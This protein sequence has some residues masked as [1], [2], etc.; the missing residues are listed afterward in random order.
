MVENVIIYKQG[1]LINM[2]RSP[3]CS[4]ITDEKKNESKVFLFIL[5]K[6]TIFTE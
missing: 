4:V 6:Y 2:S 5:G 3:W 1:A